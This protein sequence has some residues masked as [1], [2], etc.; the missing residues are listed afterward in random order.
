MLNIENTK[1]NNREIN[2]KK[3]ILQSYPQEIWL[4]VTNKCNLSCTHC[5]LGTPE[6]ENMRRSKRIDISDKVFEKIKNQVFPY[7][8]KIVFGGNELSEQLFCKNWDYIFEETA[9]FPMEIHIVSNGTL[10][11][12]ERMRKFIERE[13]TLSISMESC[14]R[15]LYEAVRGKNNYDKVFNLIKYGCEL[16][17]KLNKDKAVI[18]FGITLFRDNIY[19]LPE[20]IEFASKIGVSEINAGH[21]CPHFEY[22]RDQVLVYHKDTYNQVYD[23]AMEKAQKLGVILTMFP[24][25]YIPKI[26]E[27]NI[28]KPQIC[29][30]K[31][32][33]CYLP[34]NVTSISQEGKVT[35]CSR[36]TSIMGDLNKEDFFD[37]WNN[38]RY[39]SLRKSVNNGNPADYCKYCSVRG[40]GKVPDSSI[41]ATI[42]MGAGISTKRMLL[43]NIKEKML[44]NKI[45]KPAYYLLEK[46]YRR[47][48]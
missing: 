6:R 20:I 3:I 40:D 33:D 5:K 10:L 25:F 26:N 14:N 30:E 35:P 41:L 44:S 2:D 22:Q 16:K 24:K 27:K 18:K 12:E 36:V 31:N 8:N 47:I 42:G 13:V 46:V 48:Y 15:E 34:W 45:T 28:E 9:K 32:K 7:I 17:K 43:L 4:S 37:I 23:I 38:K 21:L 39:Q 11:T 19:E 1:L 29:G